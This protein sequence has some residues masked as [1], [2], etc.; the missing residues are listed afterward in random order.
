GKNFEEDLVTVGSDD[1]FYLEMSQLAQMWIKSKLSTN[2]YHY[3]FLFVLV[4]LN[5]RVF[6]NLTIRWQIVC[7][8]DSMV[9]FL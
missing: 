9:Y 5:S 3:A 8:M 1:E 6:E 4:L 7:F 2:L